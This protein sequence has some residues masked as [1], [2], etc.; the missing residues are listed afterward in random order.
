MYMGI[1]VMAEVL[2]G[3][4]S[5]GILSLSLSLSLTPTQTHTDTHT[6]THRCHDIGC[7]FNGIGRTQVRTELNLR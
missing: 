5:H 4:S 3:P 1:L 2:Y 6:H 7:F